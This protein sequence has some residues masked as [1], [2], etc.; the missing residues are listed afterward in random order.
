MGSFIRNLAGAAVAGLLALSSGQA[1]AGTV[2][3][4]QG[5]LTGIALKGADA[6]LGVPYA[7]PPV[8]DLR[9]RAPLPAR[10]WTGSRK[11]D[12]QPA[13]CM[14]VTNPPEGRDP[15]T[16]EYMIPVGGPMSEDCLYLDV[17]APKNAVGRR[18]PVF[19]WMHG[20]G[21]TEGSASVPV[22]DGA[23]LAANGEMIVVAINYRLGPFGFL[24]HP[25]LKAEAGASGNYGHMDQVAALQWVRDNIAAFGGD[26]NQVTLGGQSAGAGSVMTLTSSPAAKGLFARTIA[27]SGPGVGA[28]ADAY[29]V[30]EAAGTAFMKS[31]GAASLADLRRMP[32]EAVVKAGAD[33][34]KGGG[35]TFRT[36]IDGRFLPR[37]SLLT[38]ITGNA[39]NDT[40]VLAGYNADENSG[41]DPGYGQ[42][43][44]AD[45]AKIIADFG[46][47]GGSARAH[48]GA[49]DPKAIGVQM[50]RDR[51]LSTTYA[52]AKRR[53]I[54]SRSPMFLYY[55]THVE[56]GPNSA[57]YGS[58]HT[59]EVPYIFQNLMGQGRNFTAEDRQ[60]SKLISGYWINFIHTGNPNG[61][62]LPNWPAFNMTDEAMMRIDAAPAPMRMLPAETRD[63]YEARFG[64]GGTMPNR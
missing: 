19:V 1:V 33:F 41:F 27:E 40:P 56:P 57:R 58:F 21:L 17:W 59:N 64:L 26:P 55:Y 9:W 62:G 10:A 32:A 29:A 46:P 54:Q 35:K 30:S 25:E 52:W 63:L 47:L 48:Y 44:A 18:L 2:K 11:A 50:S 12:K 28:R 61:P 39:W 38:Q 36:V 7:E 45:I 13:S 43:S 23:N 16:A 8:G 49:G 31:A 3:V 60:V 42:A 20:G 4:A 34:L 37:E 15:W 51:A 53:L 6:Y 24:V 22:Y 14:Q 5:Q